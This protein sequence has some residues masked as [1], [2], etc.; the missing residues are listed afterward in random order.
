MKS[1][2]LSLF[3]KLKSF[4]ILIIKFST[5][6]SIARFNESFSEPF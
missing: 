2:F 3:F 4:F 1:Y 5:K 6:R